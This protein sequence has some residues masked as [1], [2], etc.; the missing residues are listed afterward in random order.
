MGLAEL[1]MQPDWPPAVPGW[2]WGGD[3]WGFIT[4]CSLFFTKFCNCPLKK[5]IKSEWGN[6]LFTGGPVV[7][8]LCSH[9]PRDRIQSVV[10]GPSSAVVRKL[11]LWKACG[12]AL[13][14]KNNEWNFTKWNNHT[15]PHQSY[16]VS[17]VITSGL[18]QPTYVPAYLPR[19]PANIL[20]NYQRLF[21]LK[22][23]FN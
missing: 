20:S 19:R 9:L 2:S 22:R 13:H 11:R 14:T 1:E 16:S 5:E 15:A 17:V 8:T 7:G 21:K 18:K 10:K 23:N 3:T 12:T 4:P 6:P